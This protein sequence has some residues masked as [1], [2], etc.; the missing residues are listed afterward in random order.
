MAFW[1][2][3]VW[4]LVLCG[5]GVWGLGFGE[6]SFGTLRFSR[7]FNGVFSITVLIKISYSKLVFLLLAP[8]CH[9]G[10]LGFGV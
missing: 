9:S 3:G 7:K 8:K 6:F 10:G 4:G 5:F 1:W 2:F